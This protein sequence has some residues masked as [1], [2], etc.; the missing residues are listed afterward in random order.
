MMT[1]RT[2]TDPPPRRRTGSG[3]LRPAALVATILVAASAAVPGT[4]L[5][6]G[7]DDSPASELWQEY[8]LEQQ[9]AERDGTAA[10]ATAATPEPTRGPASPPPVRT[11]RTAA[12]T[13]DD[14]GGLRVPVAVLA[15][16]AA[17]VG[18]GAW[19]RRRARTQHEGTGGPV[20]NA[21]EPSPSPVTAWLAATHGRPPAHAPPDPRRAWRAEIDWR[22]GDDGPR[23]GVLAVAE[24]TGEVAAVAESSPVPWPPKS[25]EAVEALSAAVRDLEAVAVE[26]GWTP[27]GEG[28]T[29]YAKRFAWTPRETETA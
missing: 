8:P 16:V 2:L 11:A 10:P 13:P 19:I 23:F 14:G 3:R 25:P 1:R 17:A 27:R 26:A 5:A 7:Q 18:A 29:W 28:E 22:Q 12:A 24:D 9:P 4:A 6:Q 20:G 15:I 21:A